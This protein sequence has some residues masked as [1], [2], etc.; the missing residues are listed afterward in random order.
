MSC[1]SYRRSWTVEQGKVTENQLRKK[2]QCNTNKEK[3][4]TTEQESMRA[5]SQKIPISLYI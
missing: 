1:A 5:Q 3:E 4:V 2:G